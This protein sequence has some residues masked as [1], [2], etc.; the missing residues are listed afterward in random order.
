MRRLHFYIAGSVMVAAL[1]ALVVVLS[2]MMV[3]EFI[4]EATDAGDLT[5]AVIVVLLS[6]P[7]RAYEIFPITTLIGALV[8][9]GALASRYELVAMR[10]AGMSVV[11]MAGGVLAAGLVL[12]AAA[13]MLGEWAAPPAERLA[14]QWRAQ[15]Q[16]GAVASGIAGGFWV[17]DGERFVHVERA[18]QPDLIE[19]VSIYTV[20]DHRLAEVIRAARGRWDDGAWALE[21]VARSRP[22]AEAVVRS[23]QSTWRMPSDITP[24]T[25]EVI[26]RSPETLKIGD[27]YTYIQYLEDSGLDSAEYRLAFWIKIATPLATLTMLIMTIPLIFGGLARVG[28][29]QQIFAGVLIG[30]AF[31]L[32]NRL[33][34]SAGLVYGLPAAL[35]ALAPT[36]V[37]LMLGLWGLSRVR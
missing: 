35:S 31:F 3:F 33:L 2:L 26:V 11:S 13:L 12:A 1:V 24:A 6:T 16:D 19:G 37:F 20:R 14:Q 4:D 18:P 8:G 30:I 29:G 10:A 34:A 27:L 32:A 9:L 17:R 5:S 36:A 21:D 23:T 28:T 7:Q 25:L 15:A 22:S